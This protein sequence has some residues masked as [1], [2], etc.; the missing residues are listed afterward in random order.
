MHKGQRSINSNKSLGLALGLSD[1]HDFPVAD[2][3]PGA[4]QCLAFVQRLAEI[5]RDLG[6]FAA[7]IPADHKNV[8]DNLSSAFTNIEEA[9]NYLDSAGMTA[10]LN[11]MPEVRKPPYVKRYAKGAK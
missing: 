8:M 4:G 7:S 1:E 2:V 9:E 11:R 5:R 3:S 6:H 10:L